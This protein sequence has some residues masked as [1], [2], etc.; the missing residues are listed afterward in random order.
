MRNPVLIRID[1]ESQ[2]GKIAYAAFMAL[3]ETQSGGTPE[4]ESD[5]EEPGSVANLNY[6]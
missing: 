1:L 6:L 2:S 3:P 4:Q 5:A